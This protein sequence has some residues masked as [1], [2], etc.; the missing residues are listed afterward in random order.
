MLIIMADTKEI[1]DLYQTLR[2]EWSKKPPNL[3]KCGQILDSLK[4]CRLLD[5]F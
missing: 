3:D 2:Q 4:V 5:L 1:V